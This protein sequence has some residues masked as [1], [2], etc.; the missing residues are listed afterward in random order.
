METARGAPSRCVTLN[1][2]ISL[3]AAFVLSRIAMARRARCRARLRRHA[4]R[5]HALTL[6]AIAIPY[7]L[8]AASAQHLPGTISRR[9]WVWR[10]S[11]DAGNGAPTRHR[12]WAPSRDATRWWRIY[13]GAGGGKIFKRLGLWLENGVSQIVAAL[14]CAAGICRV[15]GAAASRGR[16]LTAVGALALSRVVK[17]CSRLV[18]PVTACFVCCSLPLSW[19]IATS[20]SVVSRTDSPGRFFCR[21]MPARR[22]LP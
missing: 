10:A 17:R 20:R 13:R 21:I 15:N 2:E 18:K 1:V 3:R 22:Y 9:S 6:P 8:P 7:R 4:R 14:F 11:G 16:P 19:N 12:T 5:F